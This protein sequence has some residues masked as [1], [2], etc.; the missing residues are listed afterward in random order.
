MFDPSVKRS[1]GSR[2]GAR[3][4]AAGVLVAG[5]IFGAGAALAQASGGT[6]AVEPSAEAADRI[7]ETYRLGAGDRL[8][9]V[10]FGHPDVSGQ[11][12]VD[13]AGNITFPLLGQVEA[14][15]RTVEDLRAEIETNLNRD[16]LVN[17]SVT[18]EVLN[19]RPFF[20]LGQ[21]NEPGSY[22]YQA[23]MTV[24]QAVALAGGYT[25]RASTSGIQ[26]VRQTADGPLEMEVEEDALVFPGDT[27]E[28]ERRFF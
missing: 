1:C 26:V 28:V 3:L 14:A 5:L 9:V 4:L 23:G 18:V 11:F 12:D 20:I 27:I 10:V 2:G 16:Y 17:P 7:A 19:Y 22:A 21:V 6:A 13:G 8:Q 25:R 15:G 24:R